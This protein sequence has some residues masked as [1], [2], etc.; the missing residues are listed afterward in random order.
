[1]RYPLMGNTGRSI[2]SVRNLQRTLNRQ[3]RH[4]TLKDIWSQ[5]F[6][7]RDEEYPIEG[8]S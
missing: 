6:V 1:M 5:V 4:E 8:V 2:N 7:P 3:Y